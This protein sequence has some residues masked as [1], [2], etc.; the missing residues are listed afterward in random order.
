MSEKIAARAG[1]SRDETF[2]LL[3]AAA[4]RPGG[5]G[6]DF[7][8]YR[9]NQLDLMLVHSRVPTGG[10]LLEIGGGVSG[11]AFLLTDLYDRV[12]CTDILNV[13][14]SYGGD[15]LEAA[16][17]RHLDS[18]GRLQFVCARGEAIPLRDESVDVVFSSFVLEHI[19]HRS[20]AVAEIRRVLR[21]GGYV[22]TAVPNRMEQ[23]HR[24]LG[25][26]FAT[27]PKQLFKT[28]LAWSGLA[29]FLG[30]RMAAPPPRPPRSIA[31]AREWLRSNLSYPPHGLYSSHR[32]EIRE[33]GISEWDRLFETAG[34]TIPR[35]FT[36]TLESYISLFH[37]GLSYR[38]Q[39]FLLPLLRRYGDKPLAVMFGLSY[40]FVARKA[41]AKESDGRGVRASRPS[42]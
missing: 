18:R 35:R 15:F 37:I 30:A 7:L 39:T 17:L 1:C 6:R 36:V 38:A 5:P 23:V 20:A 3:V 14:S 25:F 10:T 2:E 4:R 29:Q 16:A 41:H 24:A 33:S 32:S 28:A 11:H 42:C 26:L 31:E 12:I 27:A 21:P 22:I 9:R 19:A 13:E 40:C 34:F 8:R